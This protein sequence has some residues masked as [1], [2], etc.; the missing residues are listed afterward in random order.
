MMLKSRSRLLILITIGALLISN[1]LAAQVNT[2]DFSE[3]YPSAV[4]PPALNGVSGAISTPSTRTPYHLVSGR[5]LRDKQIKT[6]RYSSGSTPV[7]LDA[8]ATTAVMWQSRLGSWSGGVLCQAPQ[9]SQ[10]FVGGTADISSR[11]FLS[12][13]NSGLGAALV[14]LFIWNES[15]EQASRT[16]TVGA[17]SDTNLRLDS[18][19]PGSARL[20]IQVL[21]RSGRVNAFLVDERGKG[22]RA[23]GG[24]M[25][26]STSSPRDVIYIPAI[27]QTQSKKGKKVLSTSTHILRVFVPGEVDANFGVEVI[28]RDGIFSPL[29]FVSRVAKAGMVN[30]FSFEPNL[31]SGSFAVRITSDLPLLASMQTNLKTSSGRNDFVW[32][33]QASSLTNFTIATSGLNPQLIFVGDKI[34]LSIRALFSNGKSKNYSIKASDLAIWQVPN[35]TRSISFSAVGRGI[36]A[37][38]LQS[39]ASGIG[40]FPLVA[41]STLSK[42]SIPR[43][44]IRVLNP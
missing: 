9:T 6:L 7:V 18:L 34:T 37:G 32:S 16:L 15:G 24:D 39:S 14:D 23:L 11:G 19:A 40:Y 28:S 10:W 17:N 36:F 4:C 12:I 22:L 3:N 8:Q 2:T 29:G 13:V 27:P 41:G 33:T 42:S 35:N 31:T 5:S 30:D 20:V 44:N 43:S 25:V 26:N 21:P 1:A 38:A